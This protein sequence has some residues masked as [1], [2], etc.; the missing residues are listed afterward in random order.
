MPI[1]TD[2]AAVT[3]P[4]LYFPHYHLAEALQAA[5]SALSLLGGAGDVTW[6]SVAAD[7]YRT[8][9]AALRADVERLIRAV[10]LAQQTCQGADDVAGWYGQ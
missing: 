9:L 8:Q 2:V 7:A 10:G 6:V 5:E 4:P 3:L 1:E